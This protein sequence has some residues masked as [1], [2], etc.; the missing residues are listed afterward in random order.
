MTAGRLADHE[1]AA[2]QSAGDARRL[3]ARAARGQANFTDT[4]D[5]IKVI[6]IVA[7]SA[8]ELL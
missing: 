7:R 8:L 3:N 4:L 1:T 5:N 6:S 2:R